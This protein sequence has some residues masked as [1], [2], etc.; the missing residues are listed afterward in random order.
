MPV[1]AVTAVYVCDD[2]FQNYRGGIV[3]K[4]ASISLSITAIF[5][6]SKEIT[7]LQKYLMT[8]Y[9]RSCRILQRNV[10]HINFIIHFII[11][12]VILILITL[13][14]YFVYFYYRVLSDSQ[15]H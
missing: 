3:Q 8:I 5:C 10:I 2:D 11:L 1:H 14:A 15:W 7:Y 12:V 13:Q 6:R 9:E 4:R